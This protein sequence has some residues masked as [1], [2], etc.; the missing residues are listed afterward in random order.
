MFLLRAPDKLPPEL[1]PST[2]LRY[3]DVGL[4]FIFVLLLA[5]AFRTAVRV[6]LL[7]PATLANP[8][9]AF[10]V[11]VSLSLITALYFIVRV[12][13]GCRVWTALGWCFPSRKYFLVAFLGGAGLALGVE[14]VARTTTPTNHLIPVW[15]LLLLDAVLGP[16]VEESFF[17]GCL[18]P[19][20]T[21]T[22]GSKIAVLGT[23]VLFATLHPEKTLV[24]W[25]C[26]T[27]TGVAY[28]WIRTRSG[29]TAASALMHA[30]YNVTLFFCQFR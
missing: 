29:S 8:P 30:A 20:L 5:V 12:R 14:V 19:V 27:A 23:A 9:L 16:L 4:F 2:S 26:F 10:Q 24:H 25:A 22:T 17:R 28:G 3:G 15:D 21:R 13:H 18:L 11:V 7:S 1:E 6:R